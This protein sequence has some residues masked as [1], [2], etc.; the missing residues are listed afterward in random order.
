[1]TCHI[2]RTI[3]AGTRSEVMVHCPNWV[4]IFELDFRVRFVRRVYSAYICNYFQKSVTEFY[5]NFK[6]TSNT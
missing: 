3:V 2:Q 5:Q 4:P 6:I 1:M